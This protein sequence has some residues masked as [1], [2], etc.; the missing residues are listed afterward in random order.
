MAQFWAKFQLISPSAADP[1]ESTPVRILCWTTVGRKPGPALVK[2]LPAVASV[3]DS[4]VNSPVTSKVTTTGESTTMYAASA[5]A[6]DSSE[7]RASVDQNLLPL[8]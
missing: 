2:S 6:A 1:L 8:P 7:L 3:E 4:S 5:A